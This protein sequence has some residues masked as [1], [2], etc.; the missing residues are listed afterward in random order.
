MSGCW[1][2]PICRGRL[3]CLL[4]HTYPLP[5]WQQ[6]PSLNQTGSNHERK[7]IGKT[8]LANKCKRK[9]QQRQLWMGAF[10]SKI[11]PPWQVQRAPARPGNGQHRQKGW[12]AL[13]W[14]MLTAPG[15][16][17]RGDSIP[18]HSAE[19]GSHQEQKLLGLCCRTGW[20]TG[21][22]SS[23]LCT[24]GCGH[25]AEPCRQTLPRNNSPTPQ[26][27]YQLLLHP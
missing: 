20:P 5:C 2:L 23:L 1:M 21:C 27:L 12:T 4:H 11:Q 10:C 3:R 13:L 14:S 24:Q 6:L 8:I 9:T 17:N 16:Q 18:I 19:Q 15:L 22:S 7:D 26:T 25:V